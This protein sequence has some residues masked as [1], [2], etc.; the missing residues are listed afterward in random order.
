[1]LAVGLDVMSCHASE[2]RM[3]ALYANRTTCDVTASSSMDDEVQ[4][5]MFPITSIDLILL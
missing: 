3:R 2:L 5:L 4:L 1:M